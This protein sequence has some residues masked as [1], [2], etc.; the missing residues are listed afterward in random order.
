MNQV[1]LVDDDPAQLGTRAMILQVHGFA[2]E[3]AT[4]VDDALRL[5]RADGIGVLVTDHHLADRSGVEL[6]RALRVERPTM[7]VLVLSG[8]PGLEEAYA[9]LN[10]FL[11]QKPFP[12]DEL[13]RMVRASLEK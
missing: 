6:V 2:V 4:G 12:P 5:L 1:L 3:T 11:C 7:P 10:V 13:V 8:M 9:D